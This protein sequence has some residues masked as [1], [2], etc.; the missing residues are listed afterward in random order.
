MQIDSLYHYRNS[1][2]WRIMANGAIR[3]KEKNGKGGT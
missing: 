1:N 2:C 3:W